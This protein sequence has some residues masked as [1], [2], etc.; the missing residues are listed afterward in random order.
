MHISTLV[1]ALLLL[2]HEEPDSESASIH[3]HHSHSLSVGFKETL[4]LSFGEFSNSRS[5][6]LHKGRI[7]PSFHVF[8]RWAHC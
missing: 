3:D 5:S 1:E 7:Y 8:L 4:I 6:K 2:E